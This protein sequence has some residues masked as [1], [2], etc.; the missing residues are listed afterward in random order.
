MA[1][2]KQFE[3]AQK[4]ESQAKTKQNVKI[5]P[6]DI[7]AAVRQHKRMLALAVFA[8]V[9]LVMIL[10]GVLVLKMPVVWVCILVLIEAVIAVLLHNAELWM[11]GMLLL[12]EIIAG[13]LAGK[14]MLVIFCAIVYVAA[15]ITLQIAYAGEQ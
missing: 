3:E 13:I 11:H 2:E 1:E 8:V 7:L 9:A 5:S 15:T 12:S 10:L 14:I 6:A 4:E